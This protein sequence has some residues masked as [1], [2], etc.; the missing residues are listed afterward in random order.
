MA[1][2]SAQEHLELAGIAIR[3]EFGEFIDL[4]HGGGA[5]FSLHHYLPEA[6]RYVGGTKYIYRHQTLNVVFT[7]V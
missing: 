6:V 2:L 4:I 3:A 1:Q 5:Y 7:G